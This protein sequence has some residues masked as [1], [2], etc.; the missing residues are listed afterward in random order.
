MISALISF[1]ESHDRQP[2]AKSMT[3]AWSIFF[4]SRKEEQSQRHSY[5]DEE[6]WR[7]EVT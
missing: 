3:T 6:F 2:D 1:T 7:K 5:G 4:L